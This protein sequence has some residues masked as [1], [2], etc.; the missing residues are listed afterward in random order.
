[1][2]KLLP[3]LFLLLLLAGCGK[4]VE[5]GTHLTKTETDVNSPYEGS[6]IKEGFIVTYQ[7]LDWG[8]FDWTDEGDTQYD[9]CREHEEEWDTEKCPVFRV[10]TFE[11]SDWVVEKEFFPTG[12]EFFWE[13]IEEAS[14]DLGCFEFEQDESDGFVLTSSYDE[15]KSEDEDFFIMDAITQSQLIDV[16]NTETPITLKFTKSAYNVAPD[17]QW[18]GCESVVDK[19]EVVK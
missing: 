18:L 14:I 6:V 9:Y 17:H 10:L 15:K 16:L 3:A 4:P 19:V 8:Q 12:T 13:E 2:K 11:P 7:Y 5:L 1:M